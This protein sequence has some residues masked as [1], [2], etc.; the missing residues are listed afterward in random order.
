MVLYGHYQGYMSLPRDSTY[1]VNLG[2]SETIFYNTDSFGGRI[3]SPAYSRKP[4]TVIFGE[5]QALAMD[6]N[7]MPNI[8]LQLGIDEAIIYAAPNNGPYESFRRIA[9]GHYQKSEKYLIL[10]N[11]GFDLFRLDSGWDPKQF[12]STPLE[13]SE[14][15]IS[16]PRLS[17]F[18]S[19]WRAINGEAVGF[20]GDDRD[21]KMA[22]FKS[23]ERRIFKNLGAYLEN[24]HPQS[25]LQLH[26]LQTLFVAPYW[27]NDPHEIH[28]LKNFIS[29][30]LCST[31]N[32]SHEWLFAEIGF[33]P[34]HMTR[35]ERHFNRQAVF[36]ISKLEGQCD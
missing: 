33:S 19:F 27:L 12:N 18:L 15:L 21:K 30:S 5:S 1:C 32:Q 28:R 2:P 23:N 10:I 8:Y 25:S 31:G 3:L 4:K 17:T 26:Q 13:R 9:Q 24:F 29:T 7:N 36:K 14:G 22:I 20:S 16:S 34:T 6:S 11:L 35:D